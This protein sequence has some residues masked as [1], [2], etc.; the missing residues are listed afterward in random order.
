M[1][2]TEEN[3]I[4]IFYEPEEIALNHRNQNKDQFADLI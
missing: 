1:V 4:N 3:E 2:E